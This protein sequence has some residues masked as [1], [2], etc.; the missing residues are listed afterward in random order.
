MLWC[1]DDVI[2]ADTSD[3]R[4]SYQRVR[5]VEPGQW[6]HIAMTW[7]E[8]GK[9]V[10]YNGLPATGIPGGDSYSPLKLHD[11]SQVIFRDS[12][13]KTF[14]IGNFNGQHQC[15]GFI[16]DVR[17]YSA[18]LSP[19]QIL[20]VARKVCYFDVAVNDLYF[21]AGVGPNGG[22]VQFTITPRQASPMRFSWQVLDENGRVVTA[23]E[24]ALE[25]PSAVDK[26]IVQTF[27][28]T[29]LPPGRYEIRVTESGCKASTLQEQSAYF[30]IFRARNPEISTADELQT[31]SLATIQPNL[32]MT[33]EQLLYL[34]DVRQ[35]ELDG[36]TYLEA[37]DAAGSRFV[38]RFGL[39]DADGIYLLEWDY[40]DDKVRT[41][42][43]LTQSARIQ[44]GEYELQTGYFTG[45][46]YAN[47]GRILTQKCVYYA[48]STDVALIFTTA[49]EGMPAAVAEIR[50]NK[51][52]GG[53]P[54]LGDRPASTGS[55][56]RRDIGLYY[57]DP[58]LLYDFGC[59]ASTMPGLETMLD[60]LT[61]YMKYSGQNLLTYPLVWYQGRIGD[62]YNPR[63]H[64]QDFF[65]AVLTEFDRDG[66]D[67]MVS[68][69]QHNIYFPDLVI[70]QERIDKGELHDTPISIWNTGKPNPGG[71]HGTS[72][73]FNILHPAVQANV[74]ANVDYFLAIGTK[75]PS[76][77][78]INLHIPKHCLLWL[79]DLE[80]G[81][82]DYMT[83][84]FTRDTGIA[85][86]V[87]RDDP[88][89]GKTYYEWLMAN[90]KEQWIDWRCRAVAKF[91]V[92][93]A[94]RL[95]AARPDLRLNIC[96]FSPMADI[97][98][99]IYRDEDCAEQVYR[100]AG[101]DPKY[102]Q[103]DPGITLV[104]STYPAD[105]RW[106]R[107]RKMDAGNYEHLRVFDLLP[108]TYDLLRNAPRPW[109]H[110]HD[111]YWESA[112]GRERGN[113]WDGP[114]EG[115]IGQWFTEQGWRVSTLNPA[116]YH[117]MRHYIVPLRF[118]DLLGIT[119]G[120]FLIGT[121]GMEPVLV[122]FANAFRALPAR[123]FEDVPVGTD[124]LK[125]RQLKLD[126]KTWFYVVNT[127]DQPTTASLTLSLPAVDLLDG[128]IV[129]AGAWQLPLAPYEFRSFRADGALDL[130][131]G[132]N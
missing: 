77:K 41:A 62:K 130:G 111:R 106:R 35:G 114:G 124:T 30:W 93:I 50:V 7:D 122:P 89:R 56:P 45:D 120:G 9:Q 69:N 98:R 80:A 95:R 94:E 22:T 104:Q 113:G 109:L 4:D 71:W 97:Y 102:L 38:V 99:D 20:D 107:D 110:M 121:H 108:R 59:Y 8:D 125:V 87:S 26:P 126:G 129:P 43:I 36:Q 15:E 83:D 42:D 132:G 81:Y 86:P 123:R 127:A 32:S 16:D 68:F 49:R 118:N 37:G 13:L 76:F 44:S 18:P 78:G 112:M 14:F 1:H 10:Y 79:G 60:R 29:S 12:P 116:G 34:G 5:S 6:Q 40:P 61:A 23:S 101:L 52:V 128:K 91:Y 33:P 70:N 28:M 85:V 17:V 88:M 53:L 31:E 39:P 46:E 19:E 117:A 119:K 105:Y 72:P 131:K 57:E 64:P 82:N 51:I 100:G 67:F 65:Q 25:V 84:G 96:N 24:K 3:L 58:A 66:L 115:E 73:S 90:A 55:I 75:H 2:R 63:N 27:G 21:P 11:G 103:D 47:S 92:Q 54:P 74:L 48:R